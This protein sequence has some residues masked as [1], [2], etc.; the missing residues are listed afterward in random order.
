MILDKVEKLKEKLSKIYPEEFSQ[1]H[2]IRFI[3]PMGKLQN[4]QL[5]STF[6]DLNIPHGA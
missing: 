3:Y 6:E 5:H 1:F 4:L 2:T